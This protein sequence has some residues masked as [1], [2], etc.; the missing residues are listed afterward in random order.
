VENGL[1]QRLASDAIRRE[2]DARHI[3]L[4]QNQAELICP[5]ESKFMPAWKKR[6]MQSHRQQVGRCKLNPVQPVFKA[7]DF[8]A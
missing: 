1:A 5:A 7:S 2:A 3:E 6:T 4:M 8:S